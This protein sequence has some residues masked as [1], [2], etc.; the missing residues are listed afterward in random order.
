MLKDCL[1]V[2]K[3][4]L[5]M[6]GDEFIMDSYIPADGTYVLVEPKNDSFEIRETIDI[7]LDKKTKEI[8][9]K[10]NSNFKKI[11]NYDYNSTLDIQKALDRKKVIHSNNYLSFFIKK[12]S[13]TNGKLTDEIIDNYY[14]V[15]SNP[16]MKYSKS[17]DLKSKNA[18]RIYR[19]VEEELGEVDIDTLESLRNWIKEN[20]FNLNID[21]TG[22]D[23][24]K[25]FFEYP[26]KDYERE[27]KRFLIPN[28]YNSNEFNITI[29]E[30]IYGLPNDN[31]GLN[32]KKPYL[33]NKTRKVTVPYLV[34][35]SDIL[36]QKKFFDYLMNYA[37][38][39]RVNVYI[40]SVNNEINA[41]ENGELPDKNFNGIFLRLKKGKEVEIHDY[42]IITGYKPS[43]T[44]KL[45]FKNILKI[46]QSSK[47]ISIQ[48]Y[49]NWGKVRDI[50]DRI[51][52]VFFSK[53]LTGNYF[54]EPGDL[55]INDGAL[56]SNLLLSR[57]TLFNWIYK[58]IDNGVFP[59]LNKVSLSLIKGSIENGYIPKA[60]HQ[61]NLRWSL[62]NYF[63]GGKDMADIIHDIKDT[64]RV[65]INSKITDKLDNDDEYYFAVGQLVNY[66]L[67]K[68]KG[69]NKPHSLANPFIN[70]K[71]NNE[72]K[73]KLRKL[74]AKYSYDLDMNGKRFNNLYA[75]IIGYLPE[76][77]V[78]QDL[79]VGGYLSN[80][81]IYES[82]KEERVNG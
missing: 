52:E 77:K 64:L 11:C 39:G 1:E 40:N 4:L 82:N 42:D 46:D 16:L 20:I 38:L 28:I 78:N 75:M 34:N 24:L 43:L 17:N 6:N 31:M 9:G 30:D 13:L 79:I 73:E 25:I 50:Q 49:G 47:S 23:Y 69:K 54:T 61:F 10:S 27:G 53:F 15:L 66:L 51:N 36:L 18:T 32:S 63:K 58:G 12:E 74:Y 48:K 56:K 68:S 60:S 70:G 45:E 81:L 44:K 37:A 8:S 21:I 3:T 19:T 35:N 5:D 65:K 71:N 67:S 72:I 59:V 26:I 57:E 14:E 55:S 80:N 2:F 76:D 7:R 29:K 33:E 41:Y 62:I 22:K